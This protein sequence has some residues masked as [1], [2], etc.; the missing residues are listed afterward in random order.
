MAEK[1]K[2]YDDPSNWEYDGGPSNFKG[3][4]ASPHINSIADDLMKQAFPEGKE[5]F[6]EQRRKVVESEG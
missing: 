1:E 3:E 2:L 4:I 6:Q 5:V